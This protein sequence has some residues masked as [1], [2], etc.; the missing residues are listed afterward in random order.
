[1]QTDTASVLHDAI[2]YIKFLQEQITVS[3]ESHILQNITS[4]LY[5][6]IIILYSIK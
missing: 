3:W 1:M 2:E 5:K 4:C 6:L